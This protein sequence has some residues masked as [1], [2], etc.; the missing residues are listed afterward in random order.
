[1]VIYKLEW[2]T[3]KETNSKINQ[4]EFYV[5]KEEAEIKKIQLEEAAQLIG[6]IGLGAWVTDIELI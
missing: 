6:F 4:S 5:K 2:T 1:M 3:Q